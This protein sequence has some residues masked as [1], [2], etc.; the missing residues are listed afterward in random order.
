MVTSHNSAPQNDCLNLSF[1]ICKMTRNG[2]KK[3]ISAGLLGWL[4]LDSDPLISS[5][6]CSLFNSKVGDSA[7]EI[8]FYSNSMVKQIPKS[9]YMGQNSKVNL[10]SM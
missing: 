4:L 7:V 1:A 3:A 2:Q 8:I 10:C 6:V 9:V 5:I